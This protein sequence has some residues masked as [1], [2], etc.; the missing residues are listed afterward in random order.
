MPRQND[1]RVD[2]MIAVKTIVVKMIMDKMNRQNDCRPNNCRQNDCRWNDS[3][4]NDMLPFFF[5]F[6]I[7][8][9]KRGC[10]FRFADL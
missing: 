7:P 8:A 4:Q 3:R 5:L 6:L 2:E 10:K 9:G 1:C